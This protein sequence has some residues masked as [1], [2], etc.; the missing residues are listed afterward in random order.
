[1]AD[2]LLG[3]DRWL[4]EAVNEGQRNLVFDVLMPLLSTKYY[5]LIPALALAAY[6]MA[7]GGERG[8]WA[9]AAALVAVVLADI[10]GSWVKGLVARPRPCHALLGVSLLGV[11]G[12]AFAF[13]SNHAVNMFALATA[14]GYHYR[15]GVWAV[16][17][18]AA[19]V[20]YSRVYLGVHYP[21][22]VLG[23]A[24]LGVAAGA[25]ALAATEALRARLRGAEPRRVPDG[26]AG[27][28]RV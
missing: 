22:D 8:R 3:L 13:P 12:R 10:S 25:L 23:G 16:G 6:L 2:R 5:V 27:A 26:A 28:N 20:G 14:L 17:V 19:A 24:I 18:L 11:C 7:R 9:V 21:G 15:S 1:M 4:F